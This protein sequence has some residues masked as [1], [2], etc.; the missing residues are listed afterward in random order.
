[1]LTVTKIN[2]YLRFNG[3]CR[4]AMNFYKGCLGGDLNITTYG[5]ST[6]VNQVPPEMKNKVVHSMLTS[7]SVLI[8]GADSYGQYATTAGDAVALDLECD[9]EQEVRK[10]FENLSVGGTVRQALEKPFWGGLYGQLTDKFGVSWMVVFQEA[11][12]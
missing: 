10:Y 3:N 8:Y 2:V 5:E 12:S 7:G 9:S 1:M 4:E 6:I 11:G